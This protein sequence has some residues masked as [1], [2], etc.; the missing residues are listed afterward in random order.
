MRITKR[1]VILFALALTL[2]ALT[3]SASTSACQGPPS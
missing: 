1:L 3:G 2:G